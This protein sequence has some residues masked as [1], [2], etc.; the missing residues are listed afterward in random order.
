[1]KRLLFFLILTLIV[2]FGIS[3]NARAESL[4]VVTNPCYNTTNC[5]FTVTNDDLIIPVANGD[6]IL[7]SRKEVVEFI[8]NY[9]QSSVDLNEPFILLYSNYYDSLHREDVHDIQVLQLYNP[10]NSDYILLDDGNNDGLVEGIGP[11]VG[12]FDIDLFTMEVTYEGSPFD[13]VY[14]PIYDDDYVD[15]TDE[16]TFQLFYTNVPYFKAVPETSQS[17][18]IIDPTIN[19]TQYLGIDGINGYISPDDDEDSS[20]IDDILDKF[21]PIDQ[22]K[23]AIE[24]LQSSIYNTLMSPINSMKNAIGN[25]TNLITSPIE[26]INEL[27]SSV[28]EG[29]SSFLKVLMYISLI[30]ICIVIF[31]LVFKLIII[32]KSIGKGVK[33]AKKVTTT[34]QNKSDRF[35]RK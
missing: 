19:L 22:I 14:D 30:V 33:I 23:K 29:S 7:V 34:F 13:G 4:D 5:L 10:D 3:L 26:A 35:R 27:I 21:N 9:N 2:C 18:I 6:D 15:L 16:C 24:N 25:L 20:L 8:Y 12:R 11:Y 31:Y 32:I 1:M 17:S 28:T